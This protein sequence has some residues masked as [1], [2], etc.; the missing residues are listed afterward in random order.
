MDSATQGENA[1][2]ESFTNKLV[3][4]S[5]SWLVTPVETKSDPRTIFWLCLSI[6][7]SV[8]IAYGPLRQSFSGAYV[9]QDDS[10]QHIFWLERFVDPDL[11]P[12]DLVVDY[13]QAVAPSGYKG[14]YQIAALL[15]VDPLLLSKTLPMGLGLLTTLFCFAFSMQLLPVPSSAFISTMLLDQAL[16]AGD[17]IVSS[18][19]RA[20]MY[21]MLMM[22][23]Y[24][25]LRRWS[26]LCLASIALLCLFYP[27][28]VPIPLGVIT[29]NLVRWN[30]QRLSLS[31]ERRDYVLCAAALAI[32][33]AILLPY[34]HGVAAFG[35]VVSRV[36]G[37][38]MPEFM[39]GGRMVVFREGFVSYWLTGRHSGMFSSSPLNPIGFAFA[40]L[41][42]VLWIRKNRFQIMR[43][44]S[45]GIVTF[46]RVI[47]TSVLMF[48]LAHVLLF[49]L[50]LP[51]RFTAHSFR[52]VLAVSAGICAVVIMEALFNVGARIAKR[53]PT[54][55]ALAV[56]SG[57]VL[58]W[59]VVFHPLLSGSLS[60]QKY[61]IGNHAT[62]YEFLASQPKAAIIASLSREVDDLPVFARRSILL[63]REI[64]L[65]FHK[66]YYGEIRQRAVDLINA[67]YSSDLSKLQSFIRA[68]D[69]SFLLLDK[70]AF[71]PGYLADDKW[72]LQ[73]QPAADDAIARLRNGDSPALKG[74]LDRLTVLE[75]NDLLLLDARRIATSVMETPPR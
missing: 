65:P 35:P 32:A 59:A 66:K 17:S 61:K 39:P 30:S 71:S 72:L 38:A 48:F 74:L 9:L 25:L 12:H 2:F 26:I 11:F 43:R 21:P 67:E 28:I 6:A 14:F 68:Y 5:R 40:L 24:S 23:L 15:G 58:I 64:A 50:F 33:V 10:R 47:F 49:R 18:T 46:P 37:Q 34:I 63:G 7:L 41:L 31:R 36:E 27:P 16:W 73:F 51:S 62:L 3:S 75:T 19:P 55:A 53:R 8:V 44:I 45:P 52:I 70:R 1:T 57:A 60:R 56:C 4:R 29:L 20:F 42:P 13:L 54:L 22:F 69:V